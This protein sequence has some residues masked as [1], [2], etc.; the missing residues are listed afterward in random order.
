MDLS[1][2]RAAGSTISSKS[3]HWAS[4]SLDH[5]KPLGAPWA[6]ALMCRLLWL[7]QRLSTSLCG[8]SCKP[9][10]TPLILRWCRQKQRIAEPQRESFCEREPKKYKYMYTVS[11]WHF[12]TLETNLATVQ[13]SSRRSVNSSTVAGTDAVAAGCPVKVWTALRRVVSCDGCKHI[14]SIVIYGT[15]GCNILWYKTSIVIIG[16][17][18]C[19]RYVVYIYMII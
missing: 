1:S 7:N 17:N 19:L 13:H 15:I 11:P 6:S 3:L 4:L 8:S 9:G 2:R 16:C 10:R 18:S 14:I 12:W 5:S